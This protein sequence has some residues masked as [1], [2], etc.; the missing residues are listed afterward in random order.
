[1]N[2]LCHYICTWEKKHILWNR[3][4]DGLDEI[5]A[6][7]LNQNLDLSDRQAI[8]IVRRSI[9][10]YANELRNQI[11]LKSDSFSIEE[12]INRFRKN[13]SDALSLN[14]ETIANYVIKVSYQNG[15]ISKSLAWTGYGDYILK[16]LK[17]N[18][19][20]SKTISI[21]EVPAQTEGSYEYLGKY[22]TEV[23]C[24][25]LLPV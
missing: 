13:L 12:M 24:D 25:Q 2:E 22:Y 14:E 23:D 18:S 21:Q 17:S 16:N 1:M 3:K 20:S 15:S 19:G 9:N 5:R 6:L 4:T 7:I 8:R 10:E 11:Q